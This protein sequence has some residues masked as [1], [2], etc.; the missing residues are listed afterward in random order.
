MGVR[1]AKRIQKLKDISM[2]RDLREEIMTSLARNKKKRVKLY[3]YEVKKGFVAPQAFLTRRQ[4]LQHWSRR[5]A[6]KLL[7]ENS[8]LPEK[9]KIAY[10]TVEC[11]DM[12][13]HIQHGEIVDIPMPKKP[14]IEDLVLPPNFLRDLR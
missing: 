11:R 13:Q 5:K 2:S 1:V 3:A 12:I 14:L 8:C 4:L 9:I 10:W 7:K 6:G